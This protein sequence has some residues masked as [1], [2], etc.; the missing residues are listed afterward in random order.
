[1][2]PFH[3]QRNKFQGEEFT[4]INITWLVCLGVCVHS[5]QVSFWVATEIIM[6]PNPKQRS[7][8]IARFIEVAEVRPSLSL[9]LSFFFLSRVLVSLFPL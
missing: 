9:S 4:I 3:H 6:T 5:L 7:L 2:E 1:M 8:V